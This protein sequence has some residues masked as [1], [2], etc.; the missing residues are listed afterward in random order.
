MSCATLLADSSPTTASGCVHV[1]TLKV[2]QT[3]LVSPQCLLSTKK[4]KKKTRDDTRVTRVVVLVKGPRAGDVAHHV[5][6]CTSPTNNE[7]NAWKTWEETAGSNKSCCI[8]PLSVVKC[9]CDAFDLVTDEASAGH[10]RQWC[11]YSAAWSEVAWGAC[12]SSIP[13]LSAASRCNQPASLSWI[14]KNNQAQKKQGWYKRERK[15]K[16]YRALLF[17]LKVLLFAGDFH[18]M[19]IN[20]CKLFMHIIL[21]RPGCFLP[22]VCNADKLCCSDSEPFHLVGGKM[23]WTSPVAKI[24]GTTT[25]LIQVRLQICIF[26]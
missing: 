22:Q 18:V 14:H 9:V 3:I 4:K 6:G 17:L 16:S 24:L 21:K 13:V 11:W 15:R 25:R 19:C 2:P 12:Q 5:P 26:F 1:C 23:W 7:E 8:R 20:H 10:G